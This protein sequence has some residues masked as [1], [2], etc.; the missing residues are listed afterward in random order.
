MSPLGH[1]SGGSAH[2]EIAAHRDGGCLG[3]VDLE[4]HGIVGLDL[5]RLQV[6]TDIRYTRRNLGL[7]VCV[8]HADE[9]DEA[10]VSL[11]SFHRGLFHI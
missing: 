6:V 4:R 3:R 8:G 11:R 1:G 2:E 5:D 9:Q 10:E 7:A